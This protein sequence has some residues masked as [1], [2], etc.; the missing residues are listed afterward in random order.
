MKAA[1]ETHKK[2]NA[3]ELADIL[4]RGEKATGPEP[5]RPAVTR[6]ATGNL[7]AA[8][9]HEP[10][11]AEPGEQIDFTETFGRALRLISGGLDD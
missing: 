5:L 6:L 10:N 1:T 4:A 7:A 9:E 3:Q 2:L 8:I 11:P